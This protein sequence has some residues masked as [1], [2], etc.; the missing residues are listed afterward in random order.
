M[1]FI[2]EQQRKVLVM[3]ELFFT[4]SVQFILSPLCLKESF[5]ITNLCSSFAI[6][7]QIYS[8]C[9]PF[10]LS[11][12]YTHIHC[13]VGGL[14]LV[15]LLFCSF[16]FKGCGQISLYMAL[17]VFCVSFCSYLCSVF[18]MRS[19]VLCIFQQGN[20]LSPVPVIVSIYLRVFLRFIAFLHS[21][22]ESVTVTSPLCK[23]VQLSFG[24][25]LLLQCPCFLIFRLC[26]V[27]FP[28]T[29]FVPWQQGKLGFRQRYSALVGFLVI[30]SISISFLLFCTPRA[31]RVRVHSLHCRQYIIFQ[32]PSTAWATS[33]ASA[34][35]PCS[36]SWY[37]I[38]SPYDLSATESSLLYLFKIRPLFR[39]MYLKLANARLT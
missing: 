9:C 23:L 15:F 22:S 31:L 13:W 19:S 32:T 35:C 14:C 29:I 18:S 38:L 8:H 26:V 5:I 20:I 12:A 2:L 3:L 11:D 25:L 4:I 6:I 37:L 1:R 33:M 28:C 16:I 10:L 21:F 30:T 24:Y 39:T 17:C 34:L 36:F 27:C 7:L